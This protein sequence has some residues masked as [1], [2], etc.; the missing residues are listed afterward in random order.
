[1]AGSRT[2]M[3]KGIY[4]P[5]IVSFFILSGFSLYGQSYMQ[6]RVED[7]DT[8]EPLGFVNIVYNEKGT[9]TTTN[10]NGYFMIDSEILP[11]F[12]K[13]SYVGYKPVTF[14]PSGMHWTIPWI[15]FPLN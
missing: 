11:D 8:G 1:M 7:R 12:L 4:I 15:T 2:N 13:L 5:V 9:G 10:L 14:H 6:G 3:R